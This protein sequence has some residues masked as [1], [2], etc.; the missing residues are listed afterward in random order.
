M[1]PELAV[2]T[3]V[4]VPAGVP[5]DLE[6]CVGLEDELPPPQAQ[7]AITNAGAKRQLSRE[8]R[9]SRSLLGMARCAR[10]RP[11]SA[12][13][14]SVRLV[15][16]NEALERDVVVTLTLTVEGF[17]ALRVTFAGTEQTAPV[18]APEHVSEAAPLMPAPPMERV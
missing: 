11:S 4:Y 3:I 8:A 10:T 18:G 15:G 9:R 1:V 17:V 13:S 6:L 14:Q 12:M 2:T 5:L 16:W 7:S